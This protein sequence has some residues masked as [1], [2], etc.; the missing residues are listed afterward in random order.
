MSKGW[1]ESSWT[2]MRNENKK[3]RQSTYAYEGGSE[4]STPGPF[5]PARNSSEQRL[6]EFLGKHDEIRTLQNL[7]SV[8]NDPNEPVSTLL[9]TSISPNL[10]CLASRTRRQISIHFETPFIFEPP[11]SSGF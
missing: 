11:P 8:I 3:N 5:A 4:E 6:L 9:H 2:E 7:S 10:S 1:I